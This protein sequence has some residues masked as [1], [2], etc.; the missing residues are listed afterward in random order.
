MMTYVHL[1]Q[2]FVEFFLESEISR[3]EVVQ[4]IETFYFQLLFSRK[5]C[6]YEII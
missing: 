2:Y 5:S 4:E 6:R 3:S 1:L